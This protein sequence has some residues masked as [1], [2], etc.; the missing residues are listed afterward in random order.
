LQK[1]SSGCLSPRI[2]LQNS[3]VTGDGARSL[4]LVRIPCFLPRCKRF[5]SHEVH[6]EVPV[7]H[8][9]DG[10]GAARRGAQA[11]QEDAQEMPLRAPFPSGR[12]LFLRPR[13]RLPRPLLWYLVLICLPAHFT[14]SQSMSLSPLL[15]SLSKADTQRTNLGRGKN[16]CHR[17]WFLV[18]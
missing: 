7:V 6:Q 9:G 2:L 3:S 5:L 17:P 10:D 4:L 16:L 18:T 13:D 8:E 14:C 12:R 11:P 15:C 1:H